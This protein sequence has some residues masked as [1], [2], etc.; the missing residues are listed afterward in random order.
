M[1][2]WR[3]F[4]NHISLCLSFHGL[5]GINMSMSTI[6]F[7]QQ[8]HGMDSR[9]YFIFLNVI[10]ASV[11]QHF[12]F[13]STTWDDACNNWKWPMRYCKYYVMYFSRWF[14]SMFFLF[15]SS[16]VV[17]QWYNYFGFWEVVMMKMMH[18]FWLRRWMVIKGDGWLGARNGDI[19]VLIIYI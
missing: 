10:K 15:S 18:G 8:M 6:F 1:Q 14:G 12:T 11:S 2:R 16:H 7:F 5:I 19:F 9:K 4:A 3:I 13:F 17:I